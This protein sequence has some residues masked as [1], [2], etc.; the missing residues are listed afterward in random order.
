MGDAESI[1][2]WEV[3]ESRLIQELSEQ[4]MVKLKIKG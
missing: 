1:V 2:E 3:L 4:V